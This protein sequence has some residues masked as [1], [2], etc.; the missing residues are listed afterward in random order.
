[1]IA[2]LTPIFEPK[3]RPNQT[4]SLLAR[5]CVWYRPSRYE[6]P[7]PTRAILDVVD[8]VRGAEAQL[9]RLKAERP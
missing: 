8:R 7:T 5:L 6:R 2:F 3:S 9:E 4:P 1:M